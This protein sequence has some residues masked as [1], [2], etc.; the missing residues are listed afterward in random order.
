VRLSDVGTAIDGVENAKTAAW[1]MGKPAVILDIQRQPG[2][3]IIQTVDRIKAKLPKIQ[4]SIP[5]GITVSVL[6]DRTETIRASVAD[7]QFTLVLT[8]GLVILVIFMFLGKLWGTVIPGVALPL[9]IVGTF[10]CMA[11]AGYSLDNLSLM[12]LTIAA[13]FVVDDAI[14]MIENIVRYIEAGEPP[15][16]AAYK[17]AKQ[18]GFTIVSLTVSL[19]AVFIPLLF[20]SGI[21]GRL[22][23]EFAITLT[24]AILVSRS[25]R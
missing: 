22:F 25:S 13:G 24:F 9:S 23:R 12:S 19:V 11:L 15:L 18:I 10:G 21:I 1:Y 8:I 5:A 4:L 17:G 14:V 2:A 7:V 3:N 6:A 20:M 16:E